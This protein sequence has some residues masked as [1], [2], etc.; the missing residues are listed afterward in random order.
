MMI[1]EKILYCQ[2]VAYNKTNN[3]NPLCW[4]KWFGLTPSTDP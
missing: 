4:E 2:K 1:T 3:G